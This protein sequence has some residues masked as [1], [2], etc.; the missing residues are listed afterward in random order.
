MNTDNMFLRHFSEVTLE[1]VNSGYNVTLNL[2]A[3]PKTNQWPLVPGGL[4]GLR[5]S[6]SGHLPV[7]STDK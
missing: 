1:T 2:D 6:D 4:K 7:T 3:L 5:L